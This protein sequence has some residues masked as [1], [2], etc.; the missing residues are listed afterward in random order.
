MHVADLPRRKT[1]GILGVC[2][3]EVHFCVKGCGGASYESL[4]FRASV[5]RGPGQDFW[6]VL[7][8]ST[9]IL[10]LGRD[11]SLLRPHVTL[12]KPD[13]TPRI[14]WTTETQNLNPLNAAQSKTQKTTKPQVA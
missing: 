6:A 3:C 14:F 2:G 9:L 8:K 10:I 13:T 12:N 1:F 5:Q 11:P 7:V 4:G